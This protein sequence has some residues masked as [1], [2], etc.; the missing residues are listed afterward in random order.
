MDAILEQVEARFLV[1]FVEKLAGPGFASHVDGPPPPP[2]PKR[3]RKLPGGKEEIRGK[4]ARLPQSPESWRRWLR[5]LHK[6]LFGDDPSGQ[7]WRQRA[8]RHA[9]CALRQARRSTPSVSSGEVNLRLDSLSKRSKS[10]AGSWPIS[11]II[12]RRAEMARAFRLYSGE[13]GCHRGRSQKT[14]TRCAVGRSAG[15]GTRC[16]CRRSARYGHA[17][18]RAFTSSTVSSRYRGRRRKSRL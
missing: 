10:L 7:A 8:N 12:P 14:T 18:R 4:E 9:V 11:P 16:S 6:S 3:K 17:A 2:A 13:T 5:K 15:F 1:G